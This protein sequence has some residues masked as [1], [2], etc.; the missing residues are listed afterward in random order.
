VGCEVAG[1]C[2]WG[3]GVV[4][5][6]L[7]A[8]FGVWTRCVAGAGV[9]LGSLGKGMRLVLGVKWLTQCE[10]DQVWLGLRGGGVKL[11]RHCD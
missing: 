10:G 2:G 5:V 6:G 8:G 3:W 4:V 7:A 11:L 9:W 1:V